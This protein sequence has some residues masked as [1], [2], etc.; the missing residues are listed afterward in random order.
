MEN[1]G[2]QREVSLTEPCWETAG[3]PM[4][5]VGEITAFVELVR[6][7]R[8]DELKRARLGQDFQKLYYQRFDAKQVACTLSLVT[9]QDQ[10][11]RKP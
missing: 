5:E 11:G 10:Q 1:Q 4:A 3:V 9:I 2:S 7:V 6:Y 8:D